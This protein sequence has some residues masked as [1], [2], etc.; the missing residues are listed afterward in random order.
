MTARTEAL[1][2]FNHHV[3]DAGRSFAANADAGEGAISER[4]V[5]D[6]HA[7]GRTVDGVGF[8]AAA[9]LERD[10]I[11]AGLEGT[12]V[13]DDMRAGVHVDAVRAAVHDHVF[14]SDVV[15]V[16]WMDGPH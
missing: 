16:G 9:R 2:M 15:A 6:A 10:A 5:G 4:A 11:V 13:D 14:E 1:A 3:A 8:F 12:A 7:V